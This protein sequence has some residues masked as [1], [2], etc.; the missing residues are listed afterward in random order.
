[1]K[2]YDK[3]YFEKMEN[4]N[5]WSQR[6]CDLFC[7]DVGIEDFSQEITTKNEVTE[8]NISMP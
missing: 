4:L 6:Y 7:G 2:E 1:M 3:F 5:R 8:Q